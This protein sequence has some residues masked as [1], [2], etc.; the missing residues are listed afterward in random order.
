MLMLH[1]TIP[2]QSTAG[3]GSFV[4]NIREALAELDANEGS[5]DALFVSP[6][7]WAQ[8]ESD[9]AAQARYEMMYPNQTMKEAKIGFKTISFESAGVRVYKDPF[10]PP[11]AGYALQLD[12][13]EMFSIRRIPGPVSRD[14]NTYRRLEGAD[15]VEARIGGY[16]NIACK[17][18]GHNMVLN[19]ATS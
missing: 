6:Q 19:F 16:G 14:G 13:W 4:R 12:T 18:P 17:A 10:C 7:R 15:E 11:N 8:I 5:A 9:L 3:D 2:L 1:Q